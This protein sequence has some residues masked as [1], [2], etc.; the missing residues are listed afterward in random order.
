MKKYSKTDQVLLAGWSLDCAERVLA[1]FEQTAPLDNRPHQALEAGREWMRT[2]IFRMPAIRG[3]SLAAH[4]AAKDVKSD[5]PA[6]FAA[7]AC[8]QAVATAHVPQHAYGGAYY[9]LKAL[10]ASDS[11]N[12][13]QLVAKE[14]AWQSQHLVD[15]LRDEVMSRI[16]VKER[17]KCL[18]ISIRKGPDF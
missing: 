15:H 4:A 13:A 2:G 5:P 6:S 3:A 18:F 11:G 1:F 17:R 10:A 16:I 14:L 12:A 9:A 8:G 7:H